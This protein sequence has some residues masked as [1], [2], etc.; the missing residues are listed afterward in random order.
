MKFDEARAIKMLYVQVLRFTAKEH[1]RWSLKR[2][3]R[4][5]RRLVDEYIS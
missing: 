4:Y 3:Q 2:R 5:A 1:P